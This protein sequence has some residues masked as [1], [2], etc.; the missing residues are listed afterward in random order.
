MKTQASPESKPNGRCTLSELQRQFAYDRLLA[1]LY[2]LD[3]QWVLKGA[4]ALLARQASVRH[5]TDIDIFRDEERRLAERQ[6]RTAAELDLG[7]W[8]RFDVGPGTNLGDGNRIATRYAVTAWL[9][10]ANWA[11]FRVDLVGTGVRMTGVPDDVPPVAGI[12]VPGIDQPGYR[13]Y[14][15]VDHVADKVAAILERHGDG[16]PSTRFRDLIDLTALVRIIRVNATDQ[17]TALISELDRRDLTVP[18]HFDV[19]DRQ[20]WESGYPRAARRA[21]EPPAKT[22]DEALAI[23][24]PFIDPVLARTAAGVWDPDTGVWRDKQ[25]S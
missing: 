4:V 12:S 18:D 2:A 14:P 17:R 19:P 6:M 22:L 8:F 3:D 11:E 21:V 15:L 16:R 1:R 5:S 10:P 25:M 13:A 23:V 7:D 24:V 9:G 20:L